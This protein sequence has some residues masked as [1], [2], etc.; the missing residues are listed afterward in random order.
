MMVF[1][2]SFSYFFRAMQKCGHIFGT[3]QLALFKVVAS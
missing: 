3:S 2:V 1:E